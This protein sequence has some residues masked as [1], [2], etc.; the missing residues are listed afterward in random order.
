[1]TLYWK[2][3]VHTEGAERRYRATLYDPEHLLDF[4]TGNE[5]GCVSEKCPQRKRWRELVARQ[6]E[7]GEP[8]SESERRFLREFGRSVRLCTR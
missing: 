4:R 7:S 1:M 8:L 2:Q 6:A 5:V 3:G